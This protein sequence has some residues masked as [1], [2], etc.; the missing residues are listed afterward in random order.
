MSYCILDCSAAIPWL[1]ED[2]ASPQSDALLDKIVQEGAL[3]PALWH[4]EVRNTLI[5]GIK[6]KRTNIVTVFDQLEQLASLPITT[7]HTP[8]I[9]LNDIIDIALAGK[10]TSYDATY[11]ELAAR[12]KLPLATNDK[13][14]CKI[15]NELGIELAEYSHSL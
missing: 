6:R 7:E 5:Q 10:L 11:I 3:V 14:M 15:C 8:N 12:T 2:E 1:F 13:A 9:R 4:L